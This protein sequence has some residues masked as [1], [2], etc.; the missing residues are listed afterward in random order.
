M[1]TR[2]RVRPH[3]QANGPASVRGCMGET[4]WMVLVVVLKV[5][6]KCY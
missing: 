6:G 4:P 1:C 2:P 5:T 3:A